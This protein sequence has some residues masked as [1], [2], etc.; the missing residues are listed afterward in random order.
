[1]GKHE[2]MEKEGE[3]DEEMRNMLLTAAPI[4]TVDL[5]R[6]EV[7]RGGGE[8]SRAAAAGRCSGEGKGGL[9]GCATAASLPRSCGRRDGGQLCR[10]EMSQMGVEAPHFLFFLNKM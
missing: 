7:G 8:T 6:C 2:D 10:R 5:A 3:G 9:T 4:V 1:M